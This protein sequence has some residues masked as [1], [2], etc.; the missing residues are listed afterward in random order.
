MSLAVDK[1][2]GKRDCFDNAIDHVFAP[3]WIPSDQDILRVRLRTTGISEV[4]FD[5]G[6]ITWSMNDVGGQRS[7]CNKWIH[8]FEDV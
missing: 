1:G 8:C 6:H 4:F 5:M 7:E 2:F 3:E